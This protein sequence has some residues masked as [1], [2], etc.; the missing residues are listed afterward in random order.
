MGL[1][2]R[3]DVLLL[4]GFLGVIP[5]AVAYGAFFLGLRHAHP[6]AAALAVMLEPLTATVLAVLING[7]RLS[8]GGVVG[9][10]LISG[11][12]ALYYLTPAS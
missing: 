10:L 11:A 1:P 12:L 4:V 6:T 7:E 8:P 5:T 3:S 2:L 9:T